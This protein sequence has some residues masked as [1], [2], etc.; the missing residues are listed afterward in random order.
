[1]RARGPAVPLCVLA[2]A[3]G[4]LPAQTAPPPWRR[5]VFGYP[6]YSGVEGVDL[7]AT[8]G[9]HRASPEGRLATAGQVDLSLRYT[10]AGT[11]I[12]SL[13]GAAPGLRPG[14]RVFALVAGERYARFPYYG[15]GNASVRSA[16]I[17][18]SLGP[19]YYKYDLWR[20]TVFVAAQ[21]ELGP[22]LRLHV[23]AQAR[24]YR[25]RP[26]GRPTRLGAELAGGAVADTGT[27]GGLELRAG[28]VADTRDFEPAPRRG[29]RVEAVVGR[30]VAA[31]YGRSYTRALLLGAAYVP[32]GRAVVA[33]RGQVEVASR[34][35]PLPVMAERLTAWGPEDHVG[36]FATVRASWTGRWLAPDRAVVNAELRVPVRIRIPTRPG[37]DTLWVAP[38]ADLARVWGAG[39]S[40]G[41]SGVHGGAGVQ[42]TLQMSRGGRT[43]LSVAHSADAPL[44]ILLGAG[45]VY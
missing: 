8:V 1:M 24:R 13:A 23:A 32:A 36:G 26:L 3:A 30:G 16:A 12:V 33:V 41:L 4:P 15:V 42:L 5:S 9:Y 18:D 2:L 6:F 11:R 34:R 14:W 27:A 31:L 19:E 25:V 37:A 38:F 22:W 28:L 10:G 29:T 40:F 35:I 20:A 43:S 7:N 17:E 39:E 21:R 45:F 44:R